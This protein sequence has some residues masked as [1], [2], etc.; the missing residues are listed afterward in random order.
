MKLARN[1]AIRVINI[2]VAV[3]VIAIVVGVQVI[4][5]DQ[6]SVHISQA[7]SALMIGLLISASWYRMSY[8]SSCVVA[9]LS[10]ACSS[11]VSLR[12]SCA[13]LGR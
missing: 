2:P 10:L 4:R 9:L 3:L 13:S 6:V 5:I 8:I 1:A 7:P 12:S 11:G